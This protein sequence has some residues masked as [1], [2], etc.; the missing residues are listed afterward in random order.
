MSTHDEIEDDP[1]LFPPPECWDYR[2]VRH[3]GLGGTYYISQAG[4]LVSFLV[5]VLNAL[6]K[7]T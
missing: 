7:A 2:C 4:V 3:A 6:T 1:E 5:A